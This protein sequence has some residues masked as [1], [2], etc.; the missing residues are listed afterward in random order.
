MDGVQLAETFGRTM[1][2]ENMVDAVATHTVVVVFAP[3]SLMDSKLCVTLNKPTLIRW[4]STCCTNI[5]VRA[6]TPVQPEHEDPGAWLVT[7]SQVDEA[8]TWALSSFVQT[9]WGAMGVC[10]DYT[11]ADE[12]RSPPD[13]N[14]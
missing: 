2:S 5:C 14:L 4:S 12:L 6:S 13:D 9:T 3:G 1:A 11:S 8:S 10:D 7:G